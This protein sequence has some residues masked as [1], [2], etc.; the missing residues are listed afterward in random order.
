MLSPYRF[1]SNINKKKQKISITEHEPR[2]SQM[3][4]NDPTVE[5]VS[6]TVEPIKPVQSK[7]QTE[8]WWK[9]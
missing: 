5:S 1:P 9:Y 2:S 7:K 6:E 3:S 8:G 4:S